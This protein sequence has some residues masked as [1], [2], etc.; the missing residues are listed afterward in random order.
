MTTLSHLAFSAVCTSAFLCTS[1]PTTVIV[2]GLC[3]ALPDV[4][5]PN[6]WTGRILRPVAWLVEDFGHRQITH[7]LIGS[8]CFLILSAAVWQTANDYFAA[9]LSTW[10]LVAPN[11]GYTSGWLLDAGSKTGVPIFYPMQKRLVFPFDPAFR[12]STGSLSEKVFG[13][14]LI[15]A[16]AGILYV[17]GAG[18]ALT[19]FSNLL[20]S[21][22]GG[23]QTYRKHANTHRITADVEGIRQN[24]QE[25]FSIESARVVG[26]IGDHDL[27]IETGEDEI[28]QIGKSANAH[29]RTSSLVVHLNEPQ[30]VAVRSLKIPEPMKIFQILATLPENCEITGTLKTDETGSAVL[31]PN[32]DPL[33]FRRIT[34]EQQN[35]IAQLHLRVVTPTQLRNF[36]NT[37]NA[38]IEKSLWVTGE[39][40]VREKR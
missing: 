40:I 15:A 11:I 35:G 31:R 10:L 4:N 19:S 13:M 23:V 7:S 24:T 34:V 26:H 6:S 2:G 18:G 3:G 39:L 5:T 27:L 25:L 12:L 21:T 14:V 28:L 30:H 1:D 33:S 37:A 8:I 17:N 38:S 20:G 29:V 22:S 9:N 32:I 36:R 16:L